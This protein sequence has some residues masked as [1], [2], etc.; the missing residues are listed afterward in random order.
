MT[1][2]Q[3]EELY[4]MARLICKTGKHINTAYGERLR[5]MMHHA[6]T[7]EAYA[8]YFNDLTNHTA[9]MNKLIYMLKTWDEQ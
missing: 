5:T 8:R 6:Q 9:A 3:N 2:E 1:E 7:P 4:E